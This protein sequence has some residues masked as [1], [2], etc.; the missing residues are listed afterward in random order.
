MPHIIIEFSSDIASDSQIG[1]MLDAVHQA[2][3]ASGLFDASHVRVRAYPAH[4]YRVGGS[5]DPFLHAQV[6][7]HPGRST[8][9]KKNLSNAILEAMRECQRTAHS[10]TVEIIEM[11][12]ASY[13]RYVVEDTAYFAEK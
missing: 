8:E 6:R 12:R 7:I 5:I 10:I 1:V 4:L 3:V 9:Q 11:E 2:A 13:A